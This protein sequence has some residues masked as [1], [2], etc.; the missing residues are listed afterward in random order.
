[1]RSYKEYR[2]R[3]KDLPYPY[4]CL[5]L[6]LYTSNIKT[7]LARAESKKIRVASKSVR[8][9]EAMRLVFEYDDQYQGI[10]AYH[11]A[12]VLFLLEEGFD[13]ILL[14]YPIVDRGLIRAIGEK[15]KSGK[16]VC[17]M[18]DSLEHLT[19]IDKA[20]R[21][22]QTQLPVCIDL[23]LSDDYPGLHFGVWRSS[24]TQVLDIENLLRDIQKLDYV[25][26]EG[27]MGY[28]AQIAGVA[29]NTKGGGAKNAVIRWLKNRSIPALRQ[30]RKKAI[31]LI[32]SQGIELRIV[33]GGGTG[34]LESTSQEEVVTEVT[35]GSGLFNS[36]LFDNY[37]A[38]QLAPAMFYAIPI[39]R[40][41][42]DDIYTCH[43]GGFIASGGV[44][45]IKAPIIHLPPEG[46]LD[47]NEGAGEVQTPIRFD[48]LAEDLSLGDPIFMRHAKAGELCERFNKVV[49]MGDKDLTAYPTYRGQ[50]MSFG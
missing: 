49:F 15:I 1:M 45:S 31:E 26:L 37:S 3:L 2:E 18:V 35:V 14:G 19:L 24:L 4:A 29:D 27:V 50:G 11:G 13:D 34:S 7:N 44:E 16:T 28:E 33:N 32:E 17:F 40:K 9:V 38:Y 43:G 48:N 20:G 42:K 6:E 41:P 22:L 12:E 46:R 30:K 23:D 8:C 36:H 47:K 25:K 21:A 5:D 10:M 39:V